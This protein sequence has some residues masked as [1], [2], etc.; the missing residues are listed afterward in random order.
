MPDSITASPSMPTPPL[1]RGVTPRR[2]APTG[3]RTYANPSAPIPQLGRRP[4]Y[5]SARP[6]MRTGAPTA[7]GT[8]RPPM[9]GR[10]QY[11]N[12]QQR[13]PFRRSGPPESVQRGTP[14]PIQQ[15]SAFHSQSGVLANHAPNFNTPIPAGFDVKRGL[16]ETITYEPLVTPTADENL[17]LKIYALGGLEEIGRNCTV[18]ECGDD[19]IIVD[20]GL[21]FPEEGMPGIDYIIPNV[22]TFKGREKNIRGVV[23]T[24]GHLDHVGAISHVLPKI[25]NPPIY[26][27][28]LTA[29][30]IR[31]RHEEYPNVPK[32]NMVIVQN[33][34]ERFQLGKNFIFEPFHINHTISDAFGAAIH[35][36]FGPVLIT[37][38][39]KFDFTPVNEEPADLGRIAMYGSKGVLA[40]MSDS[41][42]ADLP[43]HQISE[44]IVYDELDRIIGNTNGRL[45]IGTFSSLLT[46][47]QII[48]TLCEKYGRKVL[49]QGRSMQKNVDLA[50][51]LGY[52]QFKAGTII[53]EGEYG[54]YKPENMVIL[55]T[56]AQGEEKA[57]L[58]RIATGEHRFLKLE[59][60]DTV[61]F[62]SSVVPG[63]ERSVQRLKDTIVRHNAT[64]VHYANMDVHAGGHAKQEDLKLMLRLTKPKFFIPI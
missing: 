48:L 37:G 35:T 52:L 21:M 30:I 40:L 64:V 15:R 6:P 23:I 39:F 47:V 33:A 45:I 34:D 31:A 12:G 36:P 19:I 22:A 1:R 20:V 16:R 18:L 9:G 7:G 60:G 51:E 28:P 61:I 14:A 11:G 58:M 53:D 4:P 27:A 50:H 3:G 43:G 8:G 32:L 24:H 55:C 17:K 44:Q 25:G 29:G 13:P 57:A 38:D 49:I 56:G 54:R 26:T 41:T 5:N 63:N 59:E 10:P 42:G 62:S 2:P 46:R